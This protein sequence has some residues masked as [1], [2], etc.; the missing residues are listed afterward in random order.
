M[1]RSSGAMRGHAGCA[2][3]VEERRDDEDVDGDG[4]G[5]GRLCEHGG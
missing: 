3:N 5:T 2:D 4:G 1:A